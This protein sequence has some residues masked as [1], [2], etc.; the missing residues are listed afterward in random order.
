ML[1][2]KLS[3]FFC[4]LPIAVSGA[5][6]YNVEFEGIQDTRLLK[7][8]KSVSQLSSQKKRLPNSI[9]ALRYRAEEDIPSI[10][11]VMHSYG[12]YE[13]KVDI[14]IHSSLDRN[15]VSILIYPGS[16]YRLK[17]F[18]IHLDTDIEDTCAFMRL[19]HLEIE[20]NKPIHTRDVLNAELKALRLLAEHGFPLAKISSREIIAD[21]CTKEVNIDLYIKTGP[22]A[23]FGPLTIKG[24]PGVKSR[25]FRNKVAWKEGDVYDSRLV[26]KTQSK[27][28]D[29]ELF[30]SVLVRYKGKIDATDSL[31]MRIDTSEAK[32]RTINIGLSYQTI[33]GPGITFGWENRNI[34]R[35][36]RRLSLQGDLTHM[37]QTGIA[38]YWHPDFY[39]VGQDFISQAEAQHDSLYAYSSRSYNAQARIERKF[40]ERVSFSYGIRPEM[41]YVSES[42][43]NGKFWLLE[44]PLYLRYTTTNSLLN[45]TKGI[46][47]EYVAVPTFNMKDTNEK[48]LYQQISES[49][50]WPLD[51]KNKVVFAQKIKV[52]SILSHSLSEVPIPKRLLGGT[53][54]DLR[55]Y[56]YRTVS[57]LIDRKPL[58]GRAAIYLNFELRFQI[59]KSI[60]LVPFLDLGNVQTFERLALHGKWFK[61]VGLGFRYFTFVGPF[62]LD[63]AF[64]LDRR[65]HI[66][67]VYK[68]L[69]SIGQ[70]F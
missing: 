3:A 27:L 52:G 19:N 57:P 58:G 62:R 6:S 15:L 38:K 43:K 48:Y 39:K 10:L 23:L 44:I 68:I 24:A 31:P 4:F 2:K 12:Y 60:G 28:V 69:V 42:V 13:T 5:I 55:G 64:P 53:D 29:S 30:S 21:G 9:H 47:L 59:T 70:T 41:L 66:D 36:G 63:L 32:H 7:A 14:Q 20:L 33:F 61:S 67:S 54:E 35:M 56:R 46:S 17:T 11:S 45:P 37:I 50:Y 65:K 16:R 25:F 34:A 22:L 49:I 18:N 51:K 40:N 26:E 1:L 8:V